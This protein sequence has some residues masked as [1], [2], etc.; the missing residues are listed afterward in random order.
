MIFN[1]LAMFMC[2]MFFVAFFGTTLASMIA[3]VKSFFSK[4]FAWGDSL[5]LCMVLFMSA[6]ALIGTYSIITM[7]ET[8]V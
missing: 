3:L 1:A 2:G 5:V 4:P 8:P 7:I 6:F